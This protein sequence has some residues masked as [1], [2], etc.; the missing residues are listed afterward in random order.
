MKS[1]GLNRT[2]YLVLPIKTIAKS[3]SVLGST[4]VGKFNQIKAK[5]RKFRI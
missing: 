2:S 1:E 5:K 3:I 4:Y